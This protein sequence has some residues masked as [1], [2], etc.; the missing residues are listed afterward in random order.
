MARYKSADGF[1]DNLPAD[2]LQANGLDD[3]DTL[4]NHIS[5][6]IV[7]RRRTRRGDAEGFAWQMMQND[8]AL[9]DEAPGEEYAAYLDAVEKVTL[10]LAAKQGWRTPVPLFFI[11][12]KLY[13]PQAVD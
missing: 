6:Q 11:E 3:V 8:D 1:I 5:E 10:E 13:N 4:W 7:T 2:Y 12:E 9:A